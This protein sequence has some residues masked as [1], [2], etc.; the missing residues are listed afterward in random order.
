KITMG[1]VRVVGPRIAVT[2][3][4][5]MVDAGEA[6]ILDVVASHVWPS[7]TRTIRGSVRIPP[8]EIGERFGELP[9]DTAIIAYCT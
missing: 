6:L 8:D 7:M 9:R 3:A 2:E 1:K 4:K 5:A